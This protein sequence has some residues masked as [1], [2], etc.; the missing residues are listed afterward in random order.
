MQQNK[1]ILLNKMYAGNY[2]E[3]SN[4][5]N[6]GHE[7]I[8]LYQADNDRHYVYVMPYG[9]LSRNQVNNVNSILFVRSCG[10]HVLQI[11]AK[12]EYLTPL[13]DT[14]L[15]QKQYIDR[16]NIAYGK[17]K[18][19]DIFKNNYNDESAIY[20]TYEAKQVLKAK[21]PI[22][23]TDIDEMNA[24]FIGYDSEMTYLEDKNFS[25]R[26]LK[27]YINKKN[28]P[29]AYKKLESYI[30]DK[31]LWET[32]SVT[33]YITKQPEVEHDF[34]SVIGK[35]YDE[36]AYSNMLK[37]L[38]C[39]DKSVF[40][41]FARQVL[42]IDN[43]CENYNIDREKGNI[44]LLITDKNNVIAIEN[45]IKSGINGR[46]YAEYDLYSKKNYSQ[47]VKYDKFIERHY[48]DKNKYLFI[49]A[50]NYNKMIL[51]F[52][53]GISFFVMDSKREW[54]PIKYS[55]IYNF[56]KSNPLTCKYFDEFLYALKIH[57]YN[58]DNSLE[59][60]MHKKFAKIIENK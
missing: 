18:L 58:V 39:A 26:S 6:I 10:K 29:K 46:N 47:L 17:M 50:P 49:L 3:N 59:I 30:N 13:V 48:K 21:K 7:I 19:Y 5:C 14:H 9:T 8:N 53:F 51:D 52:N 31:N 44:D 23:I 15:K 45:K 12:A 2:I 11:I 24:C 28:N 34:I 16:N 60:E 4:Y 33:K 57:S 43:F 38:F 35:Q 37:H 22:Y 27:M 36:L 1:Q 32:K 40:C 54:K 41:K 20:Y 55:E 42:K 56:Y 25:K